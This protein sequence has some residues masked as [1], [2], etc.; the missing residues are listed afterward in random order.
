MFYNSES[1]LSDSCKKWQERYLHPVCDEMGIARPLLF[2]VHSFRH[3]CATTI[4]RLDKSPQLAADLLLDTLTSVLKFYSAYLPSEGCQEAI[5][6][7]INRRKA[8]EGRLK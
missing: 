5:Q 4:L 6:N 7:N 1:T 2:G 3:I 8:L